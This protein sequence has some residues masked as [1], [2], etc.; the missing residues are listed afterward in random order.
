MKTKITITL[1]LETELDF[2]T[3]DSGLESR[4]DQVLSDFMEDEGAMDFQ[5]DGDEDV[6]VKVINYSVDRIETGFDCICRSGR[7]MNACRFKC[8]TRFESK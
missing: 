3:D 4:L 2:S 1:D 8:K 7:E 6:E 5:N